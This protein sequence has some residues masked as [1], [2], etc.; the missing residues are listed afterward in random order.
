MKYGSGI[1]FAAAC[2]MELEQ[3]KMALMGIQRN[4]LSSEIL[5]GIQ[6][7]TGKGSGGKDRRGWQGLC[8]G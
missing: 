8:I 7:R 5:D 3:I 2:K 6:S 1:S 4:C